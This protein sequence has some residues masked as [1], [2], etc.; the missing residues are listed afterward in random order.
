MDVEDAGIAAAST[1]LGRV[2]TRGWLKDKFGLSWQVAP[3]GMSKMFKNATSKNTERA[4]AAM[5][6]MKKIDIA[7]LEAAFKAKG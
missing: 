3:P 1:T 6:Q 2:R 4:F 5:M 7:A